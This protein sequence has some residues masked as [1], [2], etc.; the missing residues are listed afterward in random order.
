M[1]SNI[2]VHIHSCRCPNQPHGLTNS[3]QLHA[4][5]VVWG[6]GGLVPLLLPTCSSSLLAAS[7][8]AR[9][10]CRRRSSDLSLV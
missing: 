4:H 3:S 1:R 2:V 8:P 5:T 10:A 9:A 6:G 7:A